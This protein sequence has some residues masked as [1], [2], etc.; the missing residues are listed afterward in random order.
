MLYLQWTKDLSSKV[1]ILGTKYIFTD[2]NF[3]HFCLSHSRDKGQNMFLFIYLF[4][5]LH[6]ILPIFVEKNPNYLVVK[7][8]VQNKI[9][10]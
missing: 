3:V 1:I 2:K 6:T 10:F 9:T 7:E 4:L 5:I 8:Q